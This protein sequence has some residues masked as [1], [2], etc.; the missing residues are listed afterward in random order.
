MVEPLS[1]ATLPLAPMGAVVE[2]AEAEEAMAVA[3]RSA[4]APVPRNFA[5]RRRVELRLV[6]VCILR[7]FLFPL[8][9]GGEVYSLRSASIGAM[10]AARLAGYTPN[11]T[12]M[13]SAIASAPTVAVGLVEMGSPMS[14]GR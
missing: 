2:A 4:V 9:F 14:P 10:A 11:R 12:P 13:A 3:A 7:W 1:A 6:S 8:R 5:Q